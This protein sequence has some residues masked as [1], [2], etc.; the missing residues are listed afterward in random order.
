MLTN[1]IYSTEI[2]Y[3]RSIH[4]RSTIEMLTNT[5]ENTEITCIKGTAQRKLTGVLSGINRKLMI[6]SIAAGYFLKK[7]EGSCPFKLKETLFG[8]L[9][10]F[11]VAFLGRV[12]RAN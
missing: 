6:S 11:R 1:T 4:I 10:N 3:I 8:V 2:T 7:F 12:A 9:Q 5:I